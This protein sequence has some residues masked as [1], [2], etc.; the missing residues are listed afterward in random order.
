MFRM[1]EIEINTMCNRKCVYCPN[2]IMQRK[3]YGEMK[4]E[5]FKKILNDLNKIEFDGRISYHFYG[6]PLLCANLFEYVTMTKAQLPKSKIFLYSNGD[7]LDINKLMLLVK[8]GVD[9]FIITNHQGQDHSFYKVYGRLES[10]VLNKVTYV[11]S[12][13]LNLVNRGGIL[14]GLGITADNKRPCLVPENLVIITSKGNVVACF[15][16]YC[17]V[18]VMGNV[19]HEEL[20]EIWNSKKYRIF[21]ENLFMGN[22]WAYDVCQAC[23]HTSGLTEDGLDFEL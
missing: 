6:E 15:N 1:V 20:S 14:W 2:S 8:L 19:K 23:N 13:E 22:R 4:K 11:S 21:R 7:Y 12:K 17:Q 10:A 5:L 18:H 16:D 9:Q 3:E